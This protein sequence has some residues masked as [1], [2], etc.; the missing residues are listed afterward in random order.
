MVTEIMHSESC[1]GIHTLTHTHT[2]SHTEITHNYALVWLLTNIT[3][4]GNNSESQP[5]LLLSVQE[6]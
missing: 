2:H 6:D 1:L 3:I 4:Q 5:P